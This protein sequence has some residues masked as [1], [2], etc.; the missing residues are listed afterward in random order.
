MDAAWPQ[1]RTRWAPPCPRLLSPAPPS[2]AR[3]FRLVSL[4]DV[5]PPAPCWRGSSGATDLS[6]APVARV[7]RRSAFA[8]RLGDP[9]HVDHAGKGLAPE[10]PGA[11]TE[12]IEGMV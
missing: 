3:V 12:S 5:E 9:G 10:E 4:R 1:S 11:L 7:R 2:T 8:Q 6:P